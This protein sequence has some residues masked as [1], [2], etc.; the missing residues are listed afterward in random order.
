MPRKHFRRFLRRTILGAAVLVV[1]IAQAGCR[2]SVDNTASL[3]QVVDSLSESELFQAPVR[4]KA[5]NEFVSVGSPGYACPTMADVDGDGVEDLV[6][7]QLHEGHMQFC[8]NDAAS[9]Q[10][11]EFAAPKWL[12]TDG[13]RAVVPGVW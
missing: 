2:S 3:D 1:P 4:I 6:V 11:P 9:G 13:E 10:P 8:K 5:G 7:G 12:E